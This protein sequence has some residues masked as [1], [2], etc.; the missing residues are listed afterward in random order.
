M[1]LTT[2]KPI[3]YL[4]QFDTS[5]VPTFCGFFFS[6]GLNLFFALAN[7]VYSQFFI[8]ISIKKAIHAVAF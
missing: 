2:T 7:L 4:L 5:S 1:C 6:N 8:S 3:I